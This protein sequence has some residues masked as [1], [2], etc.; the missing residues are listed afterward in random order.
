ML[1]LRK[2]S[3]LWLETTKSIPSPNSVLKRAAEVFSTGEQ[4]WRLCSLQF[5]KPLVTR[6]RM[7][8]WQRYI[9]ENLHYYPVNVPSPQELVQQL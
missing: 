7:Y 2:C 4:A 9:V 6:V 5:C 8:A 1:I 3:F